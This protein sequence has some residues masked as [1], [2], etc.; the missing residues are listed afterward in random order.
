MKQKSKNKT[1]KMDLSK[2]QLVSSSL[3][4]SGKTGI[5]ST[6]NCHQSTAIWCHLKKQHH[7]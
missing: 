1:I 4:L 6:K 5:S 7:V 2:W 3:D